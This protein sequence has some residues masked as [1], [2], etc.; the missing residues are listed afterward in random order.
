MIGLG[1]AGSGNG[2]VTVSVPASAGV[3]DFP[4]VDISAQRLGQQEHGQSML[5]GRFGPWARLGQAVS[6]TDAAATSNAA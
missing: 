4:I 1:D 3:D 6:A 2:S 5:Q